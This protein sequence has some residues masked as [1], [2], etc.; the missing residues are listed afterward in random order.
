V[1]LLLNQFHEL[2][3]EQVF[4]FC[5]AVVTDANVFNIAIVQVLY[6]LGADY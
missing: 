1:R 2:P 5:E 4:A 6:Q 3:I